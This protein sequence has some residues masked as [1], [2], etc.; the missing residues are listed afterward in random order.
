MS[1][2]TNYHMH[3]RF[4]DGK[5]E[6]EDY[7]RRAI[8]LGFTSI[9]TSSHA[10]VPF[11]NTYAMRPENLDA[12]CAEVH[13]LQ[14]A[15]AGQIEFALASE[16]DVIPSL[17][18]HFI[19][20]LVPRN[21]D[22]FIGSVHFVGD[23]PRIGQP[24]E[25]D[26][27]RDVTRGLNDWYAGDIRRL[28]EDFYALAR[29]VPDFIPGVAIVGHMDRIKRFNYDQR[30]FRE[31]AA[32]YRDAVEETLRV[33]AAAD[34]IVEL[35]TAGWRTRTGAGYPSPWITDRCRA[36][37]IRTTIN[38]DA[39][40]PDH[41]AADHDRAIAQLRA[42]GYHELWVRRAGTWVAEPLPE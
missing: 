30:F 16:V 38:T 22:Y 32:W 9:G 13:R 25:I 21:F 37:G 8:E 15:Y 5:G 39:H 24:W 35:N 1:L 42:S 7:V 3:S 6:I 12:Y 31:D 18:D 26:T 2:T 28:V 34:I 23:D 27:E 4:C 40:S 33:Y 17:H 20:T 10:P 14:A 41:L 11:P 19:T 29:R 36:L